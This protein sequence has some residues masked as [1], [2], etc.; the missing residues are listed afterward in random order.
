MTT[1]KRDKGFT[2]IELL[3]VIAIIGILGAIALPLYQTQL[4]RAKIGEVSNLA[5]HI[6]G[7]V[8]VY[9]QEA[10]ATGG[11]MS[12]PDCPDISSIQSS[13]GLS[14]PQSRINLA[15][16]D[17]TTGEIE[18]TLI[19]INGG[20]DGKTL[21]LTPIESDGAV[22]WQWGGTVQSAYIPRR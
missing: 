9:H 20:V 18:I 8:G 12:W 14:I 11:V 6:A 22:R 5:G 21:T 16:V 10:S 17:K 7:V 1:T 15:K 19:N 13:L 4:I 2:L 3:V